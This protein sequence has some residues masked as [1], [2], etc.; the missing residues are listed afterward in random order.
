MSNQSAAWPSRNSLLLKSFAQVSAGFSA[1]Y[2]WAVLGQVTGGTCCIMWIE[3]SGTSVYCISPL[4]GINLTEDYFP[5]RSD[6]KYRRA[7]RHSGSRSAAPAGQLWTAAWGRHMALHLG[8]GGGGGGCR[9]AQPGSSQTCQCLKMTP[10]A[11][12]HAMCC[13]VCRLLLSWSSWLLFPGTALIHTATS[14]LHMLWPRN[15]FNTLLSAAP[16]DFPRCWINFLLIWTDFPRCLCTLA[17]RA[18]LCL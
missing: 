18:A 13:A 16:R 2:Q 7:T 9:S 15:E 3:V 1:Q 8:G 6:V 12:L 11:Q 5:S 4:R 10:M 17:R 14:Y